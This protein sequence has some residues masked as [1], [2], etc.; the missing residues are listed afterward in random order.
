MQL[1]RGLCRRPRRAPAARSVP[2]RRRPAL[3]ALEGRSLPSGLSFRFHLDDPRGEFNAFP[4]LPR[5]LNAAGQILSRFLGGKGTIHVLVRPDDSIPRADGTCLGVTNVGRVGRLAIEESAPITAARTGADPNGPGAPEMVINLNAQT[6]LKQEVWFDPSG[7]ARTAVVPDNKVDFVSAVLH[8]ML[9]GCGITGYRTFGGPTDGQ[10]RGGYES[11]FDMLTRWGAG[12][13][14]SVLY[15]VGPKAMAVYGGPV[16]LTSQGPSA[17]LT[18]HNYYELG[19]PA[20][21][22]G[23]NLS[24]DLMNGMLFAYGRRYRLSKLDRAVL[25]DL[26]W[27]VSGFPAPARPVTAPPPTGQAAQ[28]PRL[29]N[30]LTS[31]QSAQRHAHHAHHARYGTSQFRQAASRGPAGRAAENPLASLPL[32]L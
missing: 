31:R 26:G 29:A 2:V 28:V 8:E 9:H 11:T 24:G 14:P 30:L 19:N 5:D 10:L 13:D 12:G 1:P 22:P 7:A 21:Q 18:S 6:Y 17:P 3:E 16:P 15:F 32:F 23:A 20:G 27:N 4:L 25:A